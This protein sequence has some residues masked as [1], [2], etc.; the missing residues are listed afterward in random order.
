MGDWLTL[1]SY[2]ET[3]KTVCR[4]TVKFRTTG[5]AHANV[6]FVDE[7]KHRDPGFVQSR[8]RPICLGL[9]GHFDC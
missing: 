2:L 1:F 4:K 3:E 8:L 9:A 6:V 7:M 5:K